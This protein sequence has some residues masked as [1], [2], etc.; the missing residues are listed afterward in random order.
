M[1]KATLLVVTL[2]IAMFSSIS[3]A[4]T[5]CKTDYWG[6]YVCTESGSNYRSTT[7]RDYW[8]ND[9]TTDNRGNS[10]TCKTDYWGNYVC[11]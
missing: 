8:G 1:I 5:T 9:V 7:K 3:Y 2:F 10:M 4:Q 6:N 11:N